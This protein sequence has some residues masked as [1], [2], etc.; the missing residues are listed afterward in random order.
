MSLNKQINDDFIAAFKAREKEKKDLLGVVKGQIQNKGGDPNDELV[1][2]VLKSIKKGLNET[3]ELGDKI[4]DEEAKETAR[5]ELT[6]IEQYF[7]ILF[8]EEKIKG[9]V[10]GMITNGTNNVNQI[11][12]E[13]NKTYKGLADNNVVKGIA[14]AL[15]N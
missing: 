8:S 1:L 10:E 3:I 5:R 15:L 11:M 2:K 9:I 12:G 6:Y 14:V 7:P 13:F 4:G